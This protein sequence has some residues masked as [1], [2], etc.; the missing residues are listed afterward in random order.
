MADNMILNKHLYFLLFKYSCL[1]FYPTA[2]KPHIPT[3]HAWTYPLWL[4]PHLTLHMFL[5]GPSS[6]FLQYH[7][8]SPSPVTVILF[9]FQY[10]CLYFAC[11]FVILIRFHL[12][13]KS[14]YLSFT[15]SLI[16]LSIMLSSSMHAV[17]K[18]RSS[19]FLSVR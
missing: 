7:S 3:S 6:I 16:S 17:M 19:F 2:P 4:C 11:L 1:H 12:Y 9:F 14:C 10:F 15:A 8:P 5:D 13:M 18:G